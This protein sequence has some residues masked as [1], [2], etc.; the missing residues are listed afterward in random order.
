MISSIMPSLKFGQT[1]TI[2]DEK[3]TNTLKYKIIYISPIPKLFQRIIDWNEVKVDQKIDEL[4]SNLYFIEEIN[5]SKKII[6]DKFD[7]LED[8]SE[9]YKK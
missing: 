6:I 2:R 9:K 7:E 4:A 1:Q 8:I 3:N 5:K